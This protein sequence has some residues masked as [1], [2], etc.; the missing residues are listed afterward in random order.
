MLA[1]ELI[2]AVVPTWDKLLTTVLLVLVVVVVA[3]VLVVVVV[4]ALI[5]FARG[6]FGALTPLDATSAGAEVIEGICDLPGLAQRA[7]WLDWLG[8]G[9]GDALVCAFA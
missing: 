6:E 3:D 9:G 5:A 7:F 2:P 8:D 4:V 1:I